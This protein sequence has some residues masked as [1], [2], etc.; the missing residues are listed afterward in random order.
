MTRRDGAGSAPGIVRRPLPGPDLV[1]VAGGDTTVAEVAGALVGRTVP[2]AVVPTGTTS[3]VAREYG[4]GPGLDLAERHRLSRP[5]GRSPSFPPRGGPPS[6]ASGPAST[7][8]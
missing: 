3:V 6:S 5:G 7:R 2:M 4:V 8:A 1:V